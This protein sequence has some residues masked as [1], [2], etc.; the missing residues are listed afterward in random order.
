MSYLK[1]VLC[2]TLIVI[3]E[4]SIIKQKELPKDTITMDIII[5]KNSSDAKSQ[6]IGTLK[7]EFNGDKITV[8]TEDKSEG[9]GKEEVPSIENRHGIRGSTCPTGYVRRGGFCFPDYDY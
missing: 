9:S 4:S 3:A 2:L 1:I 5:R 8:K 7:I 6:P